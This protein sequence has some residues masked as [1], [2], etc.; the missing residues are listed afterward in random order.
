MDAHPNTI[1]RFWQQFEVLAPQIAAQA[2]DE[3][4]DELDQLIATLGEYS[5]EIGPYEANSLYIALSPNLNVDL[6]RSIETI[7]A[8]APAI[9]GWVAIV[10]KPRKPEVAEVWYMTAPNG[11]E[12]AINTKAWD[13]VLYKFPDGIY[14]LDVRLQGTSLPEDLQWMAMDTHM[15]NLLGEFTYLTKIETVKIVAQFDVHGRG[16]SIPVNALPQVL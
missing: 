11:T 10:G 4:I 16:Q 1:I 6:V 5:W 15:V 12:I 13:C 8:A 2:T 14:E 3:L 7:V 9:P